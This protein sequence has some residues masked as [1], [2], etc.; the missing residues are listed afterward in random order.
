VSLCNVL[1][2]ILP[3]CSHYSRIELYI[4]RHSRFEY[5]MVN[6]ALC[7][8]IKALV[9]EYLVVIAQLERQFRI[10][11]LTM[12]RAWFYIQPS[13]HVMEKLARILRTA[14]GMH[15]GRLLNVIY[16]TRSR[17][18]DAQARS[19]YEH[20]LSAAAVP[21]LE[22]LS[23]WMYQGV[24]NDPY[25]EFQVYHR[26]DLTKENLRRDFNDAYWTERYTEVRENLPVFLAPWAEKVLTTGK[27]LNV[28]RE[29]GRAVLNPTRTPLMFTLQPRVYEEAIEAAH[30]FASR[31]LLTLL[32][33]EHALI[34]R[35]TS[36]KR[37]FL[38]YQGD[39]FTHFMDI[40]SEELEQPVTE[41]QSPKLES[42][43]NLAL[44]TSG[45]QTDEFQDDVG[46]YLQRVSLAQK[47]DAIHSTAEGLGKGAATP[48][49]REDKLGALK[50]IEG[51]T[52]S[53]RVRFPLTLVISK[54]SLTKYQL[55]FRHL[56]ACKHV[57][58]QVS[59]TWLNH[60]STK[61]LDLRSTLSKSFALRHRMLH[62][63][64][65]FAYY[66]MA[67]VVEPSWCAM[68]DKLE[69]VSTVD[70]VLAIHSAFLDKCLKE[71]LLTNPTLHRVHRKLLSTCL[72][73]AQ[74][75]E[76]FT[77]SV[78]VRLEN[79]E[80]EEEEGG[81]R[82]KEEDRANRGLE[83]NA[84]RKVETEHIR[85]IV[86]H[87]NYKTM[88]AR[89]ITHFDSKLA[90]FVGLLRDKS[91]S[92]VDHHLS[93]LHARLNYNGYYNQQG[94][95]H[96]PLSPTHTPIRTTPSPPPTHTPTPTPT[97]LP[98]FGSCCCLRATHDPFFCA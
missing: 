40:A 95:A 25:E 54:K 62:F 65:N 66:M 76:R 75:I 1:G 8:A 37:Y 68:R 39:F 26:T 4:S 93:N 67:E 41:S 38:L 24:V 2:R 57:E 98:K 51:L 22:M 21:Y 33:V 36:I 70:E 52:L 53:Y 32:M 12:L 83:R 11:T 87:N 55:I 59:Q 14:E 84:R 94:P 46:C 9:R 31:E 90:E 77:S 88:I 45:A 5:G 6:H 71:C 49:K 80:N 35:L 63:L 15:G 69:Q 89:F 13:M 85:K 29:C 10:G 58:R 60:Q 23:S 61:D 43:L 7:A 34:A 97:L 78:Q 56:L 64:Q 86:G 82:V 48:T 17:E 81:A 73:F 50:K 44:A 20:L 47:L 16:E 28:I 72:L 91:G 96:L 30:D 42:L 79:K 3:V 18:G 74:N 19:L 92:H 27:Y